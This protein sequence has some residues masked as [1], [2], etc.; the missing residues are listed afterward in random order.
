LNVLLLHNR[1][2]EPGGEERSLGAIAALLEARGHKVAT[3][4]RTSAELMGARGR[5]RAGAGMLAG[6]LNPDEVA[7]AV[8]RH[9]A[10]VLHAHNVNPLFGA[11]ALYAARRAGARV[12]LHVHNYRLVCAIAIEY[13]DGEVCTRCRGRNTVPGIR[14]RC[15]GNLPEAVAYGAGIALHQRRMLESVD[16]CVV[17][18]TFTRDRLQQVRVPL[19]AAKVLPNFLPEVEF[20]AAPPTDVPQHVLFAGRLVEEKGPSTAIEAAARSGVPLA[21]AGSGPD[22]RPLRD[23]ASRLAA[24]VRFLGRLGPSE[25]ADARRESACS[26]LPSRWDEPCPYAAIESMAAGTPVLGSA[27]GGMAEVVGADSVLPAGDVERWAQAMYALWN[28]SALREA[29]AAA[30]LE[31]AR[32]LFGEDRFYSGLM[33]VYEGKG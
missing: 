21:I 8:R 22:E 28:D 13:R 30:A 11:R 17:P 20:A 3:L 32:V 23:L 1:Y 24:N 10:E 26:V 18:S 5:L 31:R 4:E 33:D 6:G 15:R 27:V 16:S 12:I 2:R 7:I 19:P 25:L 29:G 14:Y 9:G